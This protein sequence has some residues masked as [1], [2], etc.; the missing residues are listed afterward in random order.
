MQPQRIKSI[1]Y[2]LAANVCIFT[3]DLEPQK[4]LFFI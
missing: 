2:I 1:K 4:T 3:A